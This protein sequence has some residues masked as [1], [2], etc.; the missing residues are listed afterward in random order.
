MSLQMS[1]SA[2]GRK[3]MGQIRSAENGEPLAFATI[4]ELNTRLW[5]TSDLQGAFTLQHL[6]Q[7]NVCLEIRSFGF[8]TQ[9]VPLT[10]TRDTLGLVVRM[11]AESLKLD[12]VMVTAQRSSHAATS[13]YVIDRAAL[14]H[15]QMLNVNDATSLLPGGKT[16]SN[17]SLMGDQR[18]AL[19]S[20]GSTEMGNASF[21]T[22]IEVD[23]IRLQ[24]NG[25]MS[26]SGASTRTVSA[27]NIASIEVVPGIPSVEYGDL[28]NGIVRI[29]TRQTKSPYIV[30]FTTKPHTKMISLCKGWHLGNR[31]TGGAGVLNAS[32]EHARS[33]SNLTTP[34]TT[35]QRNVLTLSYNHTPASR[36]R[37]QGSLT[38]NVG[39]Y[40]SESDPDA[41]T[42]TWDKVRDYALRGKFS[43]QWSP[44]KAWLSRLSLDV[45][46]SY[47]DQR[48]EQQVNASS[49][50]TQPQIHTTTE[51]YQVA[52]D[53]D[54]H[55]DAAII[56]GPTGY[57][58]RRMV[59]DNKPY[60]LSLRAKAEWHHLFDLTDGVSL[61]SRLKAGV[62]YDMTGN[63]GRGTYY[64]DM[65]VAP[66]WREARYDTLPAQ[67][68]LSAYVESHL[69]LNMR[70]GLR[71][72]LTP[73]L[74]ED[75]AHVGAS[76]YGT[77]S[78]LSPRVNARLE[79][80]VGS[81]FDQREMSVA[82]FGGW[83]K[84]VKLP[85][86]QV[87]FP[88]TT[89]QDQLAF[90]PGSMADGRAYYAYYTHPSQA[91]YNPDLRWQYALQTE[92]GVEWR[93]RGNRFNVSWYESRTH[94]PYLQVAQ[95]TPYSY[96]FTSQADLAA[97]QIPSA[98]RLYSID[99]RTGVVTV[100]ERTGSR[101]DETLQGTVRNA[102]LS[103]STYVNGSTSRRM[104]LEW[105]IDF[106]RIK[107]LH[108]DV[109][110]DGNWQRYRGEETTLTA[111]R[112]SITMANGQPYAY[113]GY[114]EGS[115]TSTNGQLTH[116]VNTNLTV[117]THVPAIRLIFTVRLEATWLNYS[118]R[119]QRNAIVVEDKSDFVGQHS[120]DLTDRYVIAYP[121]YYS[122]WDK[123][124][125]LIPFEEALLR[126]R[127]NDIE[128]YQNLCNLIA[129]SNTAYFFNP[130][131]ISPYFCG[132]LNITKEIGDHVSISFQATNFWNHTGK[133]TSSQTHRESTLYGSGYIP[134]FY[135]GLSMKVK[136]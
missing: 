9:Q 46:G 30:D 93:W 68:A 11:Q 85:S 79:S 42:D 40:N 127:D 57:W 63:A 50:S 52:A 55:P 70:H 31:Q 118:R 117:S 111:Y 78:A 73:G 26:L 74:R 43:L 56:L 28:S 54:E 86:M 120:S 37:I 87:L 13:S 2:Q 94:N 39:G 66:T 53:Y 16:L 1:A 81:W 105:V 7:G 45:S 84:S 119:L 12:S 5:A 99:N 8:R 95:Y 100:S 80:T 102:Y 10:L 89:Y 107:A 29:Q 36:L 35:Y 69:S 41:F 112:P 125:E 126:A 115:Y 103:N 71:L 22:A 6:P 77:V 15:M 51:G 109:R 61:S 98:D 25:Q 62:S 96:R 58:Y 123:P 64:T 48:E 134:S 110:L 18:I 33:V 3:V 130:N 4:V 17:N 108:T 14:D 132:N 104:G 27:A 124:E 133:V 38:G 23:G 20:N 75:I 116:Q 128:L 24:Q 88:P 49:S 60:S 44:D 135:Y 65:R 101:P 131:R 90:A 32:F 34:Y 113:V 19:R 91:R 72:S 59:T 83:G 129:R 76:A 82:L 67:H 97:S 21:G 114:Y 122:T 92:V 47:A 121:R 106:A 136:L